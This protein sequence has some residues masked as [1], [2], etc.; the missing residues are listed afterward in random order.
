[1]SIP[2][3]L[4]QTPGFNG[5]GVTL[6]DKPKPE[7]KSGGGLMNAF[8]KIM[9]FGAPEAFEA[10]RQ[11]KYRRNLSNAFKSGDMDAASGALFDMGEYGAGMDLRES[12]Q[13]QQASQQSEKARM[14]YE[15]TK[16][17]MGESDMNVRLQKAQ[18]M[19]QRLGLPAPTDPNEFT[20]EALAQNLEVMRI[21]GGFDAEETKA[22]TYSNSLVKAEDKDGNPVFLRP[23]SD[24]GLDPVEGY[25]PLG[26]GEGDDPYVQSTFIA[27]DGEVMMTM[28]DGTTVRSG[29]KTR[30]QFK[31]VMVGE[32]PH[33]LNVRTGEI[34][35]ITSAEV[36]GGNK[37]TIET[38][39][40]N[41]KNRRT[42]QKDLPQVIE[43]ATRS[44]A[45]IDGLLENSGFESR[46]GMTSVIPAIPGTEMANAQAFIDQI[47][48]QAFLEAF[49][50]LK[51]GG[52]I[53]EIEGQKATAAITRLTNQSI[54]PQAAREAAQELRDIVL[55]GIER[56]KAQASG[57]YAP[58]GAD[59]P[60]LV[61]NP[62]TGEFD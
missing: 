49:Q 5:Y 61:Y 21:R 56:A 36:I 54:T 40:E 43:N 52:Q 57:S 18:E 62:E 46:Y 4:G 42:A 45:A 51:G 3:V 28:R 8:S 13:A 15:M 12:V 53:T 29:H 47:G 9:E 35:P 32:V 26:S 17:L 33:K 7:A 37:A 60:P 11:K 41:E 48:G 22:P 58:Q 24:G 14:A 31:T 44:L 50:S 34:T 1:M 30:D 19:S 59:A 16:G 39:T 25:S 20:D 27:D 38:I 10:G 2:N 23:R 55:R 6:D